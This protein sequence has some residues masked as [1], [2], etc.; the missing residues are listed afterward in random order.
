MNAERGDSSITR[1]LIHSVLNNNAQESLDVLSILV[2]ELWVF[3]LHQETDATIDHDSAQSTPKGKHPPQS[4][5]TDSMKISPKME[6]KPSSD[7]KP[8]MLGSVQLPTKRDIG[9]Y[10]DEASASDVPS[11]SS[12]SSEDEEVARMNL[13][14]KLMHCMLIFLYTYLE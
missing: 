4:P 9:D 3:V 10:D 1:D 11:H 2:R 13:I 6:S 12:A 7:A 5:S 8:S 14:I